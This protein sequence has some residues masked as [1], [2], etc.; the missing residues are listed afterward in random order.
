MQ[1]VTYKIIPEQDK[2][3]ISYSKNYRIFSAAEPVPSAVNLV[4]FDE[5]FDQEPADPT[6]INRKVRYSFDRGNWS[7]WYELDPAGLST[8]LTDL[9]F[10]EKPLFLEVKYEYDNGTYDE[11]SPKL[12]INSVK[13]RVQST[14]V[15]ESLYTPTV[16]CSAEKCP[17]IVAEKE[18]SFK[19]YEVGSAIGISKELSYQTNKLFGHDVVYFK[20]EPDRSGGDFIF[21]EWTLF[22]TT[23]R[24]CVKVVVPNNIFPDNKPNFTEFGVDFEIPFEIHIDHTYFQSIFGPGSQPRKRDYLY[25]PI[26]N[27][28]YEIQGSYLFRGF[29]MEPM[30][31]KIQLTKFHP[32]V[33]MLMKTN[34]RKFLDNIIMTSDELFGAQAEV[35]KKDA[36][37]SQQYKTIS[38]KFDE[39]RRSLHPDL[40]NRI[41]DLTYNYAPLIEY[42]YDM[43]SIKKA[44]TSYNITSNGDSGDQ[45]LT[46][47]SP[48]E[49]YAY[50]N[51]T[52]YKAWSAKL[53]NTGDTNWGSAGSLVP[54]KMNGPK[55][56]F[57]T[58]G[59]YVV[60]E[61]Y[62]NLGLKANERRP[63]TEIT[64]GVLQFNQSEHAV[65]YKSF[66]STD[67]TPNLT[68]SMLVKF[69]NVKGTQT[70]TLLDGYSNLDSTGFRVSASLQNTGY[71]LNTTV[72]VDINSDRYTFSVGEL[73]YDTWYSIIV[74]VSA[75]FGQ[76]AVTVYSFSQDPA[77]IKNFNGI[78]QAFSSQINV[79]TFSF[80]TE[81]NWSL[82]AANYSAANIRVFNTMV[83]AEDHEFIISQLFIRDESML[84]LID[85]ARPR[86]NVPFIAINK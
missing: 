34:D 79:G 64:S 78:V 82:P 83:Q 37:D 25:M 66:A 53:L 47:N 44:M 31:W 74:P 11:L 52:I 69:N 7:L 72:Y 63:I 5:V 54:I 51:S 3:S 80:V 41:L 36:L 19:P 8:E 49:V 23:D 32:N 71:S 55:D 29:M 60:V 50:E 12:A 16:Y 17:A 43:S 81:Q 56:S 35:Q 67:I 65:V 59:K 62:K 21:K 10:N 22:Q 75:Q 30:Y 18:A 70:I 77:N 9:A 39:T 13:F 28:M 26:T 24:K 27:R 61:G 84:Q 48:I 20:T 73:S 76:L 14:K 38:H 1:V 4:G 2:N 45:Y 86:L 46:P 57:S 68:A 42:Y 85:N 15:S 6:L 40:T 58:L 33:D